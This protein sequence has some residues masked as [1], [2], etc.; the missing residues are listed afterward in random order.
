MV[1]KKKGLGE[2]VQRTLSGKGAG[3][4]ICAGRHTAGCGGWIIIIRRTDL[5]ADCAASRG[6]R[7]DY[8]ADSGFWTVSQTGLSKRLARMVSETTMP[9]LDRRR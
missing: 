4:G 3:G 8:S 2:G 5:A 1:C 6:E 9:V 7:R